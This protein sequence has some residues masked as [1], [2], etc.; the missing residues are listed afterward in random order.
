MEKAL[1]L[2]RSVWNIVGTDFVQVECLFER[3]VVT[4]DLEPHVCIGQSMRESQSIID[5][6]Q[7]PNSSWSPSQHASI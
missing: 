4:K 5:K 3:V 1:S 7:K 2:C 6:S